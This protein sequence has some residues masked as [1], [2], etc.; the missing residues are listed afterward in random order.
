M[1]IIGKISG[2][3]LTS[4]SMILLFVAVGLVELS[5]LSTMKDAKN[6][7]LAKSLMDGKKEN[8]THW[9][10]RLSHARRRR[11][12]IKDMN[13]LNFILIRIKGS[14]PTIE[15]ITL[16]AQTISNHSLNRFSQ[17]STLTENSN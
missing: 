12:A 6:R 4:S 2:G 5:S 16:F 1:P 9:S 15:N 14:R 3:S 11:T 8:F 13:V 7:K 17:T 10:T